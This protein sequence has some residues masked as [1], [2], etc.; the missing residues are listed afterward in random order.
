MPDLIGIDVGF[1]AT[2]RTTGVAALGHGG[3]PLTHLHRNQLEQRLREPNVTFM[4]AAV[5]GPVLAADDDQLRACEHLFCFGLFGRRCRPGLSHRGAGIQFRTAGSEVAGQ[6]FAHTSNAN[7]CVAFLRVLPC[8]VVEAFPNAFLAVCLPEEVHAKTPRLRRGQRS[9]WLYERWVEQGT[10]KEVLAAIDLAWPE[11]AA[12]C[13]CGVTNHDERAAVICLLT[14][15]V[16][17]SGSYVAVGEQVGGYFFLPPWKLWEAWA[18]IELDLQ[19][20]RLEGVEV[21]IDGRLY[22][23]NEELP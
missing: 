2:R 17:A 3:L 14:A 8:N 12:Q 4:A 7:L 6:V 15:A 10:L 16:V 22:Q 19:R 9:D 23:P 18:K 20:C 11:G 5:D 13:F 21:W 1:S